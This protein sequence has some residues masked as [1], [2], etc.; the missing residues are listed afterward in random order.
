MMTAMLLV[1]FMDSSIADASAEITTLLLHELHVCVCF[2]HDF[3]AGPR[4][5]HPAL[6]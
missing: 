5:D 4:Q 1:S 6:G 2:P 3:F